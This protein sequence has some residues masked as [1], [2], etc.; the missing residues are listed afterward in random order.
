MQ[1]N[2]DW[3]RIPPVFEEEMT[4][5]EKATSQGFNCIDDNGVIVLLVPRNDYLDSLKFKKISKNFRSF[6]R[7]EEYNNSYGYRAINAD[8]TN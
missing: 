4:I 8:N 1:Y 5:L 2:F 7:N 3:G 6:L